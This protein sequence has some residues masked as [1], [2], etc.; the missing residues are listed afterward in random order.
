MARLFL[1]FCWL[2]MP[3]A[4]AQTGEPAT[5]NPVP[6][7]QFPEFKGGNNAFL[8]F[9]VKNYSYP[10]ANVGETSVRFRVTAK[11]TIG[12]VKVLKSQSPGADKELIRV[13][14]LTSGKWKPG[15]IDGKAVDMDYIQPLIID[16]TN[17]P[18]TRQAVKSS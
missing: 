9:I 18:A 16:P 1:L 4:F 12:Q 10:N 15:Q 11:G 6:V 8:A 14:K 5:T 3:C 17:K 13:I 2:S 7:Q